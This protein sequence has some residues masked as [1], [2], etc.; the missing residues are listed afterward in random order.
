MNGLLLSGPFSQIVFRQ[1]HLIACIFLTYLLG[2][3]FPHLSQTMADSVKSH[4]R[5]FSC[6]LVCK[7]KELD[8]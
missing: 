4:V 7:A 6:D 8:S 2:K 5:Y 3:D 1:Y